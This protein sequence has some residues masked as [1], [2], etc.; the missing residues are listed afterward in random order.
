M[1]NGAN[2]MTFEEAV[3]IMKSHSINGR[4]LLDGL[5][6]VKELLRTDEDETS[7]ARHIADDHGQLRRVERKPLTGRRVDSPLV[8]EAVVNRYLAHSYFL[9]FRASTTLIITLIMKS[10]TTGTRTIA[11]ASA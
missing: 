2:S 7:V 3:E 11:I 6:V 4:S 5:E 10:S 8:C 1:I 9:P